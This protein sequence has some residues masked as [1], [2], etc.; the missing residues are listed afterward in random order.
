MGHGNHRAVSDMGSRVVVWES[1]MVRLGLEQACLI[2][3]KDDEERQGLSYFPGQ[4][5]ERGRQVA[6][7]S[8]WER[9]DFKAGVW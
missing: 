2:S 8:K 5:P 4:H 9:L 3:W 1:V 6:T 7:K